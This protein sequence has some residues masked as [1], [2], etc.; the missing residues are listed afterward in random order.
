MELGFI[1]FLGL[2]SCWTWWPWAWPLCWWDGGLD[3]DEDPPGLACWWWWWSMAF[4]VV[5]LAFLT[6]DL[7][8]FFFRFCDFPP[9]TTDPGLVLVEDLWTSW[10]EEARVNL[11]SPSPFG[12]S[13]L[14]MVNSMRTKKNGFFLIC[15]WRHSIFVLL[16]DDFSQPKSPNCYLFAKYAICTQQ[17]FFSDLLPKPWRPRL[18]GSPF[19][20]NWII[21]R[22]HKVSWNFGTHTDFN[23]GYWPETRHDLKVVHH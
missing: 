12:P 23:I 14:L 19:V 18:V 7:L 4:V 2:W 1:P 16:L 9:A 11:S 13:I 22:I 6:A 5:V 17:H 15:D 21:W 8:F 20:E 3:K 10:M